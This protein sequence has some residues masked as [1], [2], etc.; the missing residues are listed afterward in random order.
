MT[1]AILFSS[2]AFAL[3]GAVAYIGIDRQEKMECEFWQTEATQYPQ[4]Y[5]THWQKDQCDHFGVSIEAPVR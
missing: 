5:L 3:F 1:Q 2:I 4:Y